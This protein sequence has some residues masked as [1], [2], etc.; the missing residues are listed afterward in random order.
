MIKKELKKLAEHP[1]HIPGIYNYC[2]YW[3]E[4]CF[5]TSRC[6]NFLS[7]E[8]DCPECNDINNRAFWDK[9]TDNLET[10]LELAREKAEEY[11]VNIP[12]A[13]DGQETE[14][15]NKADVRNHELSLTARK[16]ITVVEDWF[17]SNDAVFMEKSDELLAVSNLELPG[18]DPDLEAEELSECIDVIRWY[19]HQIHAKLVRAL[20][21][22][23]DSNKSIQNDANGSA[24]VSL[25]AIDLSI[26]AWTR[27]CEFIPEREDSII[28]ILLR[29]DTCRKKV[30]KKFRKARAF[31]RP[32]FDE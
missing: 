6:L 5:F 30:E 31:V 29:L 25:I 3:C 23:D 16:Y 13:E 2:D 22:D 18:R 7:R 19:Q 20:S 32:G 4:K 28:D 10:A 27:L 26:A 21:F 12:D 14:G 24:K 8:K 9:L 11:G 15:R 1:G 17:K